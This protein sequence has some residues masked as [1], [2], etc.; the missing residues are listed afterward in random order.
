[1]AYRNGQY[2]AHG[3]DLW[4]TPPDITEE[5]TAEFGEMFDPCPA[6]YDGSFDGL[7]IP[8]KAVNFV[9]PPY[10]D[11]KAWV[12]KC[13]DEWL[14]GKTVILLIP[15]RTCSTYFHQWIYQKA[16][17]RFIKGRV[18]FIDGR[19]PEAKPSG[20]PFPSMLCVFHGEPG[21]YER[22]EIAMSRATEQG[23]WP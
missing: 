16:E 10:G 17:L 7:S 4:Q 2:E 21:T 1:M 8:W 18:K 15:P 13:H 5:L 23:D 6:D 20:A 11:M 22:I 14:L 19:N 9:N 12:K 3:Y